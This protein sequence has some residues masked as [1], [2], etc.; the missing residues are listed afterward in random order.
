[1]QRRSKTLKAD[2]LHPHNYSTHRQTRTD[3]DSSLP[4]AAL[5]SAVRVSTDRRMDATEYIIS[6]HRG[7]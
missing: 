6:L 3:D 1:M 7:R 2:R 4:I 5:G